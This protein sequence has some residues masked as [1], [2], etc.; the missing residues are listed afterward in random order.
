MLVGGGVGS[1]GMLSR[2]FFKLKCCHQ[3]QFE[4]FKSSHYLPK[5]STI[6]RII[7][8]HLVKL[9]AYKPKNFFKKS[10]KMKAFP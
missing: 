5:K 1:G 4:Y 9:I 10:N 3:A 8:P 6:L 2:I 7:N